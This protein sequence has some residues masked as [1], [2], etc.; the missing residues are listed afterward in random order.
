M[1]SDIVTTTV[2]LQQQSG[3]NNK[4]YT[5]TSWSKLQQFPNEKYISEFESV[6][7]RVQKNQIEAKHET[8][9]GHKT[10]K[11]PNHTFV[12]GFD[13]CTVDFARSS[14]PSRRPVNNFTRIKDQEKW[15]NDEAAVI[16]IVFM[17]KETVSSIK[18]PPSKLSEFGECIFL[19]EQFYK[20]SYSFVLVFCN[21]SY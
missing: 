19:A 18:S 6:D 8:H 20:A 13:S 5:R 1:T 16:K 14:L 10:R 3:S 9:K 21:P 12:Q 4:T 2:P 15:G 17:C 7:I 11:N